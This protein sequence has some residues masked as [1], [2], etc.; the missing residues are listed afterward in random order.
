M[1][2]AGKESL[3]FGEP[4]RYHNKLHLAEVFF[5]QVNDKIETADRHSEFIVDTDTGMFVSQ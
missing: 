1:H 2:A 4:S 5:R 3:Y